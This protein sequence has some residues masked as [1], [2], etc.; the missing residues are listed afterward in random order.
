[1]SEPA[2]HETLG[3]LMRD[4]R[5][6]GRKLANALSDKMPGYSVSGEAVNAWVRGTSRPSRREVIEALDEILGADDE[7]LRL[8]G[9][10]PHA[11]NAAR[12]DAV[13]ADVAE[14]KAMLAELRS[15]VVEREARL[16][17]S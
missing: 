2:F 5:F 3:R 11:G 9:Y 1:M 12:L 6:S 7:L 8:A 14:I 17:G 4:Q 15:L 16:G 10:G 13:E